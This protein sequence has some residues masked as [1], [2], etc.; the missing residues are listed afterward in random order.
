VSQN[1]VSSH[2]T[3]V[4]LL[5][6]SPVL[7]VLRSAT[8]TDAR[9]HVTTLAAA[10]LPVV[11]LTTTTP[12]WAA[13]LAGAVREHPEL[14]LGL[15]TVRDPDDVRRAHDAGARFVVTPWP[16]PAVR[17][18]ATRIGLALVEGGFTPGEIAAA[19]AVGVA[20]LFPAQVVGPDFLRAIRPVLPDARVVPTGGIRLDDVPDWLAAGA[21]TVGV[22]SDLVR[23]LERDP[24]GA[25]ARLAEIAEFA[26]AKA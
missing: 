1:D 16:A 9:S 12:G 18:A 26:G 3:L 24:S 6:R 19:A 15:G 20:K 21:L 8:A 14:H 5:Q 17:A 23:A 10:G 4:A 2:E 25:A 22:G 11:E 13:A 7:P